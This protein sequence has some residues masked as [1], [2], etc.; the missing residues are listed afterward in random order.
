M[1]NE[2]ICYKKM[3]VWTKDS[4][5]KMFQ[6]K[7]NTKAGTWGKLTV[8]KGKLKFYVLTENGDIVSEHIFTPQDETPFVEPQLWHRVEALSDDLECFLEFYCTKEDYFSKKYNMTA[9]HG[10]VVNAA[11]IIKPCKVLDL[12]WDK[13]RT[14]YYLG[15]KATPC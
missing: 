1:Q 9:T 13:E 6:E 2:L 4:L 11:K 10:D 7:H 15:E 5:P 12:G 8:L 3:P 14:E